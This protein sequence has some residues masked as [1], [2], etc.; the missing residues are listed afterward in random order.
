MNIFTQEL[1]RIFRE[2]LFEEKWIVAP[3]RRVAWQWLEVVAR[4]GYPVVNVRLGYSAKRSVVDAEDTDFTED[5]EME[6]VLDERHDTLVNLARYCA[7]DAMAEG[8]LEFISGLG[9][10]VA[11]EIAWARLGTENRK[12][13]AGVETSPGFFKALARTIK[14]LR[15]AGVSAKEVNPEKLEINIKGA[16]IRELLRSYATVLREKNLL[17]YAGVLALAIDQL[18]EGSSPLPP[19]ALVIYPKYITRYKLERDL[20]AAL[21]VSQLR[22]LAVDEPV[23][24]DAVSLEDYTDLALLSWLRNPADAPPRRGDKTASIFAAVGE[25]NEV[26]EVFRRILA[27][28]VPLD[29][30]EV[31]CADTDVYRRLIYE[32]AARLFATDDRKDEYAANESN[33]SEFGLPVTFADGIPASYSRPGR[34]LRAWVEWSG[35]NFPQQTL[36]RMIQDGLIAVGDESALSFGYLAD[37]LR[38]VSVG[39]DRERYLTQFDA[40]IAGF[41]ALLGS[42][43]PPVDEDGEPLIASYIK[44]RRDAVSL[45]RDRVSDLLGLTPDADVPLIDVLAAGKNFLIKF[46]RE[47][48]GRFDEYAGRALIDAIDE[49]MEWAKGE[50]AL[51]HVNGW[52]WLKNLPADTPVG[53]AGPRPGHLYV[54]NLYAGGYS[55]R[56]YTFILGLDDSRFPGSGLS[57]PVLLD[58]ER[59]KLSV[60]LPTAEKRL[61]EREDEFGRLLARLRG[62]ATLSYN[63]HDFADDRESFPSPVVVRAYR[64]LSGER[65]GDL[66]AMK[67]WIGPPASFCPDAENKALNFNEWWLWRLLAEDV[68]ADNRAVV[69]DHYEN[70]RRGM[71][72]CAARESDAFTCYDGY[73]PEA[74]LTFRADDAPPYS[75]HR[76]ETI[77]ACPRRF[78]FKYVLGL[79]TPEYFA[80]DVD[81]WLDAIAKG[82]LLHDVFYEFVKSL[83][84][85]G[86]LPQTKRDEPRLLAILN[87]KVDEYRKKYPPT[88]DTVFEEE[89]EQLKK[90]CRV[91]LKAEEDHCATST[92]RHCEVTLGMEPKADGTPLDTADLVVIELPNNVRIRGRGR[93]DRV[94]EEADGS[95]AIWDYKSGST[96]RFEKK[97][98]FFDGRV[99]Q[100]FYYIALLEAALAAQGMRDVSVSSF[101]YFFTSTKGQGQRI[102]YRRDE[103][104]ETGQVILAGLCGV[105]NAGAYNATNDAGDCKFCDYASICAAEPE[106]VPGKLDNP[107]NEALNEFKELR[108]YG[109]TESD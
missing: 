11:T 81:L 29:Y 65:S 37:E 30:V 48:T 58:S 38:R 56:P 32:V 55:G 27:E 94:D 68:G 107:E 26:R 19:D 52:D 103:L 105:V 39:A 60:D 12:Y 49:M 21:P 28:G 31:I 78:F 61:D 89:V 77:G 99:I 10:E 43:N 101:G 67:C 51:S 9:V 93:L 85:E 44:R 83:V 71:A 96:W 66:Q 36:V 4:E 102:P 62:H 91:F 46:K 17:D 104:M 90:D 2:H 69:A 22:K 35:E 41:D 88:R 87:R 80:V 23:A 97:P 70:L 76:L 100:N 40:L 64:L 5:R 59:A 82:S 24:G 75:S 8:G 15:L 109:E 25:T 34:A 63:C 95:L 16:A 106:F 42:E 13:F 98:P 20:L 45:L 6:Y 50:Q 53:G 92:P 73:V 72:A 1:A 54:S 108:S 47:Q 33:G 79:E 84:L 57:E 74:G 86:K 3:S 14:D 7:R 18:N